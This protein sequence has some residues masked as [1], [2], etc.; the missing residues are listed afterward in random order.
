MNA[1]ENRKARHDYELLELYEAGVELI[2]S[3]VKSIRA[4]K[5]SIKEAF[6]RVIKDQEVWL[7]GM[8][9]ARYENTDPRLAP[10]EKR[11]RRL[12]LHKKEIKKISERIKLEKLAL[13]PV[14]L[15]FNS[16]NRVKMQIALARGKKLYDKREAIKERDVKIDLK[17][18]MKR[19]S[20]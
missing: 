17:R 18:L 12:L 5:A 11:S 3:E 20:G 9:I 6:A 19:A 10:D 1:I 15:Y 16:R 14:K 2:G 13:I 7:F 8:H 4:G